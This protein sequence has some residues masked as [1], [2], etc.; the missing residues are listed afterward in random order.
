MYIL[1]ETNGQL[2]LWEGTAC[3]PIKRRISFAAHM[4]SKGGGRHLFYVIF[5]LAYCSPWQQRSS[6]NI[7]YEE[8]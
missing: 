3:F 8:F 2:L 7:A 5:G 1:Y 4:K 6:Q